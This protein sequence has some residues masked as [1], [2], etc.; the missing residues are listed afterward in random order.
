MGIT[1]LNYG[2]GPCD[3][4]FVCHDRDTAPP[5]F[6][7]QPLDGPGFALR[8]YG[9]G[10]EADDLV[11]AAGT[12]DLVRP[13]VARVLGHGNNE[14]GAAAL[15]HDAQGMLQAPCLQD[16]RQDDDGVRSLGLVHRRNHVKEDAGDDPRRK[17]DVAPKNGN[18]QG[19]P[20]TG[21]ADAV[22]AV[23][24]AAFRANG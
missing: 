3:V 5:V 11:T 24:R 20:A 10:T 21:P 7:A 15:G 12:A 23:E 8:G 14:R 9:F 4:K 2:S 16:G 17:Q 6:F 22:V 19:L 18:D 13:F 1:P